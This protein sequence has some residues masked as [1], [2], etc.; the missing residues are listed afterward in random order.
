MIQLTHLHKSKGAIIRS[1]SPQYQII[2]YFVTSG[3]INSLLNVGEMAEGS[4]LSK[5]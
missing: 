1:S 5:I 2:L 3:F 4:E